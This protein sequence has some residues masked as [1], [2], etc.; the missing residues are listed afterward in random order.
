MAANRMNA[1]ILA[2]K[3]LEAARAKS[4]FR[5]RFLAIVVA[6]SFAAKYCTATAAL[7]DHSKAAALSKKG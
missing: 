7:A 2:R 4:E 1:A 5:T 6:F 3:C